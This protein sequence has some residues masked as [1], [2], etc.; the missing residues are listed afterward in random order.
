MENTVLFFNVAVVWFKD[1][2]GLY[3]ILE[4]YTNDIV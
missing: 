4:E 1:A 3:A 2:I